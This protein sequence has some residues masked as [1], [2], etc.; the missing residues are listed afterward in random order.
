[1]CGNG[2]VC[3]SVGVRGWVTVQ[4]ACSCSRCLY[5]FLHPGLAP[6][7]YRPQVNKARTRT[8]VITQGA[9]HTI[10]CHDGVVADF[11]IQ[12]LPESAIVDTNGAGDA[13]VGGFLAA[14]AKRRDIEACTKAASFAA[15]VIIQ[16]SGCTF[17]EECEYM[18]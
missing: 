2:C 4:P 5:R 12:A 14:L 15:K 11:E 9:E 17:P 10:I 3:V 18:L 8:V 7:P 16:R 13:W 6:S 1:M